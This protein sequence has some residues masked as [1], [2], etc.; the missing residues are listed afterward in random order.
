MNI[1]T[2]PSLFDTLTST[3]EPYIVPVSV[4]GLFVAVLKYYGNFRKICSDIFS[5]ISN[6]FGWFKRAS[7]QFSV[8]T[9][10]QQTIDE[11]NAIVPELNLPRV[12]LKSVKK[13]EDG[14]IILKPGEAIILLKYN[15]DNCQNIINTASL[16]VKKTLLSISKPYMDTGVKKAIDFSVIRNFLNQTK[17][18]NFA[19]PQFLEENQ[20][21]IAQYNETFD[22]VSKIEK[23]GLFSRI[24]LREYAIWGNKIA[25]EIPNDSHK[26]ESL[27]VLN[28]IYNIAVREYDELTPLS[29][30][31]NNVKVAILLVA[32]YETFYGKGIEPY[33]RRIKEGFSKGITTFY[34]LARNEKIDI[35]NEV[36]GKLVESGNYELLNGPKRYKD[37]LGRDNICYC[38]EV[39]KNGD[40]ATAYSDV[41]L[42]KNEHKTIDI[43]ITSVLSDKLQGVYNGIDVIIPITEISAIPNLRLKNFY[44]EGMT[45]QAIPLSI[46]ERGSV[47]ASLLSTQSEPNSLVNNK[48]AIGATVEAIVEYSDDEFIKLRIKDSEQQARASRR[49]LTFS[50]FGFLH[51]L[52]P[53]GSEHSFIIKEIDYV[54]NVLIL[55]KKNL[56]DPWINIS[57]KVGDS[58]DC[59][60]FNIEEFCF[61]TEL[62]GD[63]YAILPFSELSWLDSNINDIKKGIKRRSIQA[64]RIK[65]IN[66]D[67]RVI[68]LTQKKLVSDYQTYFESIKDNDYNTQCVINEIN[69]YGLIGTVNNILKIFIPLS[70]CHIGNTAYN[71]KLGKKYTVKIKEVAE[72]NRSLIGTLKPFIKTPLQSFSE[73]HQKGHVFTSLKKVGRFNNGISFN[74]KLSKSDEVRAVLYN[75]DVSDM[76]FVKD[77]DLLF[78]NGFTCPLC[79]KSINVEKNHIVLSLKD[80]L[81]A[82]R[83]KIELIEYGDSVYGRVIGKKQN[84]YIVLIENIW[85]DALLESDKKLSIGQR[86]E[87]IKASSSSFCLAN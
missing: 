56:V 72:D 75:S 70:E 54:L 10:C 31:T 45:V 23:E 84:D 67:R 1:I 39:K 60:I 64:V 58:L 41:R 9:T 50:R 55:R 62:P 22:K 76:C 6:T 7:T 5:W 11:F 52:F 63:Y 69:A 2:S 32:K 15:R 28:F 86:V 36:Y 85:T 29:C 24:L 30:L 12:S 80:I 42:A 4:L 83:N 34:L 35:L 19:V 74:V 25:T 49:D 33:V 57:Y 61:E 8:E 87:M 18:K 47:V 20:E 38:I 21:D 53:V 26:R 14:N 77:I 27:D 44:T 71:Y 16:Y 3:F 59:T 82:N 73:K 46:I 40:L 37:D 48:Y 65:S 51:Q 79:I 66:K 68:I 78:D 13:D 81:L 17:L 43:I